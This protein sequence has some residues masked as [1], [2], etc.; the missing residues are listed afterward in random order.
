MADRLWRPELDSWE[1]AEGRTWTRQRPRR[2]EEQDARRYVLRATA[3]VAVERSATFELRWL[4]HADRKAYWNE[5]VAG[6]VEGSDRS[7]EPNAD[8]LV[9]AASMW[10]GGG[11]G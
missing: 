3:L 6:H 4:E 8:G 10:R 5:H 9:Y 2:L 11:R 1:D 7:A